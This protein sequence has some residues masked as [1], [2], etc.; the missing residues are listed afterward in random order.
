MSVFVQSVARMNCWIFRMARV[1][2]AALDI[3]RLKIYSRK[4][5]F[6]SAEYI[7]N[8]I[9]RKSHMLEIGKYYLDE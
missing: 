9:R 4:V 2:A 6:C 1:Q 3:S 7:K 5:Q 8:N